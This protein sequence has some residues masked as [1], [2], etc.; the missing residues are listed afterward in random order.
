MGSAPLQI[1]ADRPKL[2][3]IDGQVASGALVSVLTRPAGGTANTRRSAIA[4]GPVVFA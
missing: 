4:L 1:L 2:A 3:E